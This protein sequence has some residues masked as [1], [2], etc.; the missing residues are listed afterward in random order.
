ML[1]GMHN[2]KIKKDNFKMSIIAFKVVR[3]IRSSKEME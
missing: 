1:I 2:Y 3:L